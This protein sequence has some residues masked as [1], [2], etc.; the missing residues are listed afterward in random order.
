M[1]WDYQADE[2]AVLRFLQRK[3]RILKRTGVVECATCGAPYFRPEC[4][5]RIHRVM[6]GTP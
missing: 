5:P 3:A 4:D 2:G 1:A 6:E